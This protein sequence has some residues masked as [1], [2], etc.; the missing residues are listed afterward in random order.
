MKITFFKE[1]KQFWDLVYSKLTPLQA[2]YVKQYRKYESLEWFA[3]FL[4][5]LG[6]LF[7]CIFF[8]LNMG[9]D[10]IEYDNDYYIAY[11]GLGVYLMGAVLLIISTKYANH[12]LMKQAINEVMNNGQ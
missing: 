11:F 9:L 2:E 4:K 8:V 7:L 12:K 6:S 1:K 5:F 10:I 3:L